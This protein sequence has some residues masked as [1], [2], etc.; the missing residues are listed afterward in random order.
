MAAKSY[1]KI[2][3]EIGKLTLFELNDLVEEIKKAFGVEASMPMMGAGAGAAGAT[4][5]VGSKKEEQ[6]SF[7]VT[8]E[9]QGPDKI[10][11]I[12]ALRQVTTLNLSDAKAAVEGSPTVIAESA[13]KEDAMKMKETLEAAGAKVKLS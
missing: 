10:K 4:E 7:K 13:S 8:L 6:T 1:D 9:D 3:E 12:K 5:D 11:T 2:V